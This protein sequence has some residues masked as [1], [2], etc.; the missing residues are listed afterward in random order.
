MDLSCCLQR[1]QFLF[2]ALQNLRQ[3]TDRKGDGKPSGGTGNRDH[4]EITF[5]AL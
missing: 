2:R 4:Y 1:H 3:I 5:D